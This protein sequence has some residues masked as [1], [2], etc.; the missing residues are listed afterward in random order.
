MSPSESRRESLILAALIVISTVLIAGI[1]VFGFLSA[2][3]ASRRDHSVIIG[4]AENG[5]LT[6][7]N[8]ARTECI[9]EASAA[10]DNA[11]WND[12]AA[13]L[14]AH[15][16][17]EAAVIGAQLG[18]LPNVLDL[19]NQGGRVAGHRLDPCPPPLESPKGSP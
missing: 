6:E 4:V 18:Q 11:R 19:A 17:A 14:T 1:S 5:Q 13:L 2:H 9:R 3:N 7:R 15:S 10:L 16:R 8:A 12:V